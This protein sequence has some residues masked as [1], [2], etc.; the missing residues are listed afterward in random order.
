M[1]VVGIAIGTT[2]ARSDRGNCVARDRETVQ[3]DKNDVSLECAAW[4]LRSVPGALE[5]A[6]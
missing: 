1:L 6:G 4:L 3:S 5:K 2:G